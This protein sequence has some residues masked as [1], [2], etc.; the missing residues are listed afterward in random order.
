MLASIPLLSA[1]E[2]P[3]TLDDCIST[4][5]RNSTTRQRAEDALDLRASDVLQNYG[6][7]LPALSAT[8]SYTPWNRTQPSS[9]TKY[10]SE[11]ASVGL[12]TSL[13]LFN[14]FG[15]YASLKAAIKGK[16]AAASSLGRALESIVY[17]VTQ[18]WYQH[19]LDR[20]LL[21]I[22][23]QDLRS[24]EDQLTLTRRQF[25]IGLKAVTDLYQQEAE[26]ADRQLAVIQREARSRSSR[27]ELLRRLQIDPGSAITFAEP[28]DTLHMP[29][30]ELPAA[31]SLAALA[32]RRRL[33]L[34]Q[35]DFTAEA[36]RWGI[37]AARAARYPSLDLTFDI[38]SSGTRYLPGS[39]SYDA[40][41]PGLLD[42]LDESI[43]QS[44]SLSLTWPL[45]T[46]YQA[47]YAIQSAKSAYLNSRLDRRDLERDIQIDVRKA[48]GDY[49][50]AFTQI[51]AAR[52]GLKAAEAAFRSVS[53]KYELGASGFVE[54]SA[55][56]TALFSARSSL[57]QARYNLALQKTILD[58]ATGTIPVPEMQ[59][60]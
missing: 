41:E 23:R 35:A 28:P 8:A 49:A 26:T 30:R 45:F 38:S 54:L 37:T 18:S 48:L 29:N 11:S 55:A 34:R 57:T 13:N 53:R 17:D 59:H 5:L 25:Q 46:G 52:S 20:E 36:G 58:Y 14:G 32:L 43:G 1:E 22:A 40:A 3:L 9:T 16:R 47:S 60:Y 42:Q 4:A 15:D 56:R 39:A 2:R 12:H 44:V 21:G 6:S 19:Q 27:L 24:A 10:K 31:D 50:S 51:E 7:F 33:D